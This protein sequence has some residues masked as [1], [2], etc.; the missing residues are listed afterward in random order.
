VSTKPATTPVRRVGTAAALAA[1]M[2]VPSLMQFA[3]GTL[4]PFLTAEFGLSRVQ[5]GLVTGAYYCAAAGLSPIMGYWV[6]ALGA[7]AAMMLTVVL[8]GLGVAGVS[9]ST[10]LTAVLASVLVGGAATAVAN[11]ATNLAISALP[12]PHAVLIGVKQSGVQAAAL[13]AGALLPAVALATDWRTAFL[14]CAALC[15]LALPALAA[16]PGGV[17]QSRIRSPQHA[18][19]LS[20]VTRLSIYSALMGAGMATMNTYLVLYAHER[21]NMAVGVAGSLVAVVGVC[22]VLGRINGA[23]VVERAASAE[24]TGIRMLRRMSLAAVG[25]TVVIALAE[26]LGAA[27]LWLGVVTIGLSAAAFNG[28]AMLVVIRTAKAGSVARASARVQGAFFGGLFLS[29]PV[30]GLLVDTL[31]SYTLGWAWTALCF[32]VAAKVM[33]TTKV[34]AAGARDD[35]PC[36]DPPGRICAAQ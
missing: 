10:T 16:A 25:A 29:P 36:P 6:G 4:G 17:P 35:Q 1:I 20:N 14:A 7:R 5:L 32:G 15:V 30:F 33:S 13:I 9:A 22:A 2:I 28:V 19:S 24:R 27:A 31:H 8:A 34:D 18:D 11:P 3:L 12:R 26:R 21:V 23:M